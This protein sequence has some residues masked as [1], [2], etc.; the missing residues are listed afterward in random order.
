MIT[1][2][3]SRKQ[4]GKYYVFEE[5]SVTGI[6]RLDDERYDTSKQ[7]EEAVVSLNLSLSGMSMEAL[8]ELLNAPPPKL[9]DPVRKS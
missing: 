4:D 3:F 7:A 6:R 9:R 2:Y 1:S 5:D 8:M